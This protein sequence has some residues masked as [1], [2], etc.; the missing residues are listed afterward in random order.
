MS[1]CTNLPKIIFDPTIYMSILDQILKSANSNHIN[2]DTIILLN[3]LYMN[4]MLD[5]DIIWQDRTDEEYSQFITDRIAK[6]VKIGVD[7]VKFEQSQQPRN[8]QSKNIQQPQHTICSSSK[9]S[10]S[11]IQY[12][13]DINDDNKTQISSDSSTL[14]DLIDSMP[15]DEN[16]EYYKKVNKLGKQTSTQ[17]SSNNQI[18]FC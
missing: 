11:F 2:I 17:N 13:D 6:F 18:R 10:V 8:I 9:K 14:S 1:C 15:I 5:K 12:N 3:S 7:L 16:D 4:E